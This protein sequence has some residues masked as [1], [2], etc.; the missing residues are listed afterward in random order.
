MLFVNELEVGEMYE[1]MKNRTNHINLRNEPHSPNDGYLLDVAG[2]LQPEEWFIV[3][4][5]QQIHRTYYCLKILTSRGSIGW[6][7]ELHVNS[8]Y[9]TIMFNRVTEK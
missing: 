8:N 2:V 3:L 6:S 7:G 1:T 5:C 9:E 4:D